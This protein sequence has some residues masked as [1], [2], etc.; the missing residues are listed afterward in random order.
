MGF[1]DRLASSLSG[2]Q[3]PVYQPPPP[4]PLTASGARV[5]L[6]SP[7]LVHTKHPDWQVAAWNY[8]DSV[9]ELRYAATFVASSL[10]RLR[11]FAAQN[12][13]RGEDPSPLDPT[14]TIPQQVAA[15]DGIDDQTR[16]AAIALV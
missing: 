14:G 15:A 13:P 7:S 4:R 1:L 11:V 5:N 10:G 12:R 2:P 6:R 9:D 8:R 3:G 16:A